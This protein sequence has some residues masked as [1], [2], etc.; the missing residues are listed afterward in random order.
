MT[1]GSEQ[2]F[3]LRAFGFSG[4]CRFDSGTFYHAGASAALLWQVPVRK[5]QSSLTQVAVSLRAHAGHPGGTP[6]L[7]RE[8]GLIYPGMVTALSAPVPVAAPQWQ[9]LVRRRSLTTSDAA[10]R[11]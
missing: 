7:V 2:E 6:W 8:H 5:R 4:W 11:P 1:C 3:R 10:P 9:R